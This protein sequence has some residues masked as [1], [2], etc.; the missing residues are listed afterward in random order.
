MLAALSLV[1]NQN[2]FNLILTHPQSLRLMAAWAQ[3]WSKDFTV[4]TSSTFPPKFRVGWFQTK[5]PQKRGAVRCRQQEPLSWTLYVQV[6]VP[7]ADQAY[8]KFFTLS[9]SSAWNAFPYFFMSLDFSYLSGLSLDINSFSD[10]IVSQLS[11][12]HC[13]VFP[14]NLPPSISAPCIYV[15]AGCL[16]SL[17]AWKLVRTDTFPLSFTTVV[18]AP[19]PESGT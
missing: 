6:S 18:L 17:L 3:G 5:Y 16:S 15:L 9:V 19:T 11:P 10:H 4:G 7:H 13:L 2:G 1:I 12:S 8:L 14:Y